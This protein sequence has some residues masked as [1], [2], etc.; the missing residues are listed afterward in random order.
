VGNPPVVG[1]RAKA[2]VPMSSIAI[3]APAS[4]FRGLGAGGFFMRVGA[5]G[6]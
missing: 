1:V 4:A 2:G 5:R 6:F 3:R